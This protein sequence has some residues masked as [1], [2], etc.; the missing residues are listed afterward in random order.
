MSGTFNPGMGAWRWLTGLI[1]LLPLLL[2]ACAAVAAPALEFV[3]PPADQTGTG[4]PQGWLVVQRDTGNLWLYAPADDRWTQLTD[5]ASPQVV[6]SQPTWSPADTHI[7][8]VRLAQ[9]GSVLRSQ[10]VVADVQ[11]AVKSRAEVPFPPFYLYWNPQGNRL[12][13]LSNAVRDNVRT[14]G[15]SLLTLD[16]DAGTESLQTVDFGQPYYYVWAPDRDE[17]LVHSSLN[18]LY[19]RDASGRADVS[20]SAAGFGAPQ[21][22]ATREEVFYG[23]LRDGVATL[24]KRDLESSRA[25]AVS[26]YQ[27]TH[28][29][30]ALNGTGDRLAVVETPDYVNANA[31][32]PLYV[33]E[34]DRQT[35]QTVTT[36]PVMAA[37]WSPDGRRLLFWEADLGSSQL[38]LR[39]RVWEEGRV[40]DLDRIVPSNTLLRHYLPFSDQYALSHRFWSPDSRYIVYPAQDDQGR[41]ALYLHGTEPDSEPV[42][43]AYGELAF[44]SHHLHPK[45]AG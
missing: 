1:C 18:Q 11:G 7:A 28:L 33:Y 9:D 12:S 30:L 21:W 31:F 35:V 10:L 24:I 34:L 39:L 42:F 23:E 29:S 17:L 4:N 13:Y 14:L 37:F 32:G 6:Y 40:V 36:E 45:T 16:S 22:S 27:G 20:V 15:L 19:F 38:A 3:V 43:L 26:Y 25:V 2:G 44:W 8:W 5:D 41:G